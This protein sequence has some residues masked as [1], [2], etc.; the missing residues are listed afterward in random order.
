MSWGE[1]SPLWGAVESL[2]SV[3]AIVFYFVAAWVIPA[4]LLAGFVI[5][6]G[7]VLWAL[8]ADA[9]DLAKSSFER[10]RSARP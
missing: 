8:I 2:V 1:I 6:V 3:L 9:I 7:I 5:P 10:R 4:G